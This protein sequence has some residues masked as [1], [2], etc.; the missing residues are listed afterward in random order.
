MT[1]QEMN[2]IKEKLSGIYLQTIVAKVNFASQPSGSDFDGEGI[3][4]QI[5][6]R[7]LGV[8]RTVTSEGSTLNTQL[9][10]VSKSSHSMYE[11]TDTH[12]KY[13]LTTVLAPRGNTSLI[14]VLLPEEEIIEEWV[15]VHPEK[16][17]LNAQAY[18]YRVKEP[19]NTGFISIPKENIFNCDSLVSLFIP[20]EN[21]EEFL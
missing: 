14:V 15:N 4:W 11:E 7:R 16:L 6:N 10:S 1:P 9:K 3:D 17:V 18:Y 5:I 21:K 20:S 19:L 8:K 12:F 2:K 13:N